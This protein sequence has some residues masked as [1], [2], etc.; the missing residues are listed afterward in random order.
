MK[1]LNGKQTGLVTFYVETSFYNGLQKKNIYGIALYGAD[2]WTR[3]KGL[4][5]GAGGWKRS[6]GLIM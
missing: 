2:T 5:C 6:V 1:Y 3:W 4:N